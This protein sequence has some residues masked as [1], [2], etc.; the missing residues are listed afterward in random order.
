MET[1]FVWNTKF[2]SKVPSRSP[3]EFSSGFDRSSRP[4]EKG[5]GPR[6]A[7]LVLR[8]RDVQVCGDTR[9]TYLIS[10]LSTPSRLRKVDARGLA[11]L[12]WSIA[13]L[14][15]KYRLSEPMY[16]DALQRDTY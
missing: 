9:K 1:A 16:L 8:I 6:R 11:H 10:D 15:G 3:G 13:T 12:V 7:V 4:P 2:V 14:A 5:L